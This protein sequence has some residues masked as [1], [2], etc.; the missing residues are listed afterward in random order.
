[1]VDKKR[2][3]VQWDSCKIYE[4]LNVRRCFKCLGF[5]HV[6][7]NCKNK[8]ACSKCA[9]EHDEKQCTCVEL[10]CVNCMEATKK[11]KMNQCRESNK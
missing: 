9:E 11:F 5:N 1:M 2:V 8:I 7:E 10:K 3:N 4:Y 6:A